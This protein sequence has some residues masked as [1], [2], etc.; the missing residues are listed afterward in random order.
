[1]RFL[2]SVSF[3]LKVSLNMDYIASEGV[4]LNSEFLSPPKLKLLSK[5]DRFS[6]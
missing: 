3:Y 2:N 5:S 6:S 4:F 1:M